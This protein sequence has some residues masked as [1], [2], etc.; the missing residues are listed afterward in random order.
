MTKLQEIQTYMN[1]T[2]TRKVLGPT[3]AEKAVHPFRMPSAAGRRLRV[4]GVSWTYKGR[5]FII[6]QD[7]RSEKAVRSQLV[8]LFLAREIYTRTK[9]QRKREKTLPPTCQI[10]VAQTRHLETS[11]GRKE[12][13]CDKEV[14]D[15]GAK[16]RM[17]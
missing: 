6:V 11:A 16:R 15:Q 14:C 8:T 3:L 2:D 13:E 4:S 17:A 9:A 10:V 7:L 12:G 5:N 1:L